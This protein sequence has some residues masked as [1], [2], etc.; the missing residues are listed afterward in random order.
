VEAEQLGHPLDHGVAAITLR[1]RSAHADR[2]RH[3]G[4]LTP[5]ASVLEHAR[6]RR[7]V[8]TAKVLVDGDRIEEP[9]VELVS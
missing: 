3:P 7:E 2:H 9:I 8:G 6:D 5:P 1:L 4:A